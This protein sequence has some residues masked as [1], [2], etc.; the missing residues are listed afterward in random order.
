[1]VAPSSSSSGVLPW[2]VAASGGAVV[3]G[4]VVFVV[5]G[6]NQHAQAL[7]EPVQV[8]VADFNRSASTD[9]TVA[10][11]LFAAGAAMAAGGL[12]W[13][14]L[15]AGHPSVRRGSSLATAIGPGWIA[16]CG[17]FP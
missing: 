13:A 14:W 3:L 15:G 10:N 2:I 6:A 7:A 12:L 9:A 17:T 1:V 8:R 11:V 5:L 4:G 16:A